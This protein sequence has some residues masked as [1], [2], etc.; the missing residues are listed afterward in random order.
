VGTYQD[1]AFFDTLRSLGTA[2]I[3]A[4]YAA[5]GTPLGFRAVAITFKNLTNGDV[6]L[7]D[8]GSN[9]KMFFAANSYN[10]WDVR[11]NAP[12]TNDLM[13]PSGTQFYLKD[14]PTPS[15]TGT[16]YIEI[17]VVKVNP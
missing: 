17:L 6:V 13:Y 11:T 12:N 9:D 5:I 4:T 15:T 14:G 1:Q 10:V 3:G 2:G 8:D 16:F 7:S